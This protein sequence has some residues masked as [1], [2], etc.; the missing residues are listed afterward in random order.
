MINN[1]LL[2]KLRQPVHIS[3]ISSYIFKKDIVETREII[4]QLINDD[5]I[6]ESQYSKD[7]Y[8]LKNQIQK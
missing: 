8:K 6:E 3:Y 2:A 1:K 4:N 7:Y 5:V